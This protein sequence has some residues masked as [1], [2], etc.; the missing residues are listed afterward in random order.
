MKSQNILK[1]FS[2]AAIGGA[3]A[4]GGFYFLSESGNT[5]QIITKSEIIKPVLQKVNLNPGITLPSEGF[6]VA[7]QNSLNSV[8][9]ITTETSL[10]YRS[11]EDQLYELL[12]GRK[13]RRAPQRASG[14]GVILSSDGYIVTNNHVVDRA[15]KV[16]VTLNDNKKYDAKVIGTDPATDM[17]VLKIEETGLSEIV[18]GNSDDVKVGEWVVAV[19]NPFNLT[20]T[21]TAGIV[22]AKSR[23]INIMR[24]NANRNI[25]PIESFI[26]TDAAVNPGNSGGALVN[27]MGEL[28][29]I[30]TAI[31][32]MTGSYTGYSFA[33]PVNIMKKVTSDIIRYGVVQRGFIGVSIQEMSQE[34]ADKLDINNAEGV[35]V[36]GLSEKGAA[37][38]AGLKVGDII[39]KVD[40]TKVSTVPELQEQ[41]GRHKPGDKVTVGVS[42][43]GK[44]KSLVVMLRNSDGNTKAVSKP[45]E[46]IS[47][48]MGATF[49]KPSQKELLSLG[50]KNGI[51]VDNMSSGKLKKIGVEKGFIITKADKKVIKTSKELQTIL[52]NNQ[53]EGVLIEGYYPNGVK[54]YY[55]VGM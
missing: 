38:Q 51:K 7:A 20:S 33:V 36:N 53:G 29:G 45:Q 17:A 3:F 4:L 48:Y 12:Y 16:T 19:G 18:I 34:L 21:V 46:I 9:H 27:T 28:I 35:Y 37:K 50:I 26:Q 43:N 49:K 52:E 31:A 10:S 23:S 32:S 40:E 15:D 24:Q 42:R 39:L 41:I 55:G 8:V 11:E 1:T 44:Y 13:T 54:A 2:V 6:T 25:F 22:S 5:N 47:N 14:S 30:N